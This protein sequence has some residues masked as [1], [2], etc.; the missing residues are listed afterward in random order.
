MLTMPDSHAGDTREGQRIVGFTGPVVPDGGCRHSLQHEAPR[1]E[2]LARCFGDS[3]RFEVVGP[4]GGNL[5]SLRKIPLSNPAPAISIRERGG[6][7]EVRRV[8]E[9]QGDSVIGRIELPRQAHLPRD[10]LPYPRPQ[11]PSFGVAG[12][13]LRHKV[14]SIPEHWHKHWRKFEKLPAA[15]HR[16]RFRECRTDTGNSRRLGEVV[17][18]VDTG[19]CLT[20]FGP[21]LDICGLWICC[22][23]LDDQGRGFDGKTLGQSACRLR[24]GRLLPALLEQLNQLYRHPGS[25]GKLTLREP[26]T[27]PDA[28]Q[29]IP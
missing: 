10:H 22:I 13:S 25:F 27:F 9:S 11:P 6:C 21:Q 23:R 3:A 29:A 2:I 7:A 14:I 12:I 26:T 1:C 20:D 16:L 8:I 5:T 19:H 28:A 24:A 17:G 15:E 18:R 4:F